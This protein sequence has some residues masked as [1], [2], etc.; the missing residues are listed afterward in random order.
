M[1]ILTIENMIEH[2]LIL[3]YMN[4]N[5]LSIQSDDQFFLFI[6]LMIS[7]FEKSFMNHLTWNY[8]IILCA[9]SFYQFVIHIQIQ[10]LLLSWIMLE[11][12]ILRYDILISIILIIQKL[13]EMCDEIEIHLKYLSSYSSDFNPIE[14]TFTELKIWIKKNYI[15]MKVYD[16]FNQFLEC[17]L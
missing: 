15:L 3:F 11:F 16:T 6:L 1:N 10:D 12:I 13:Q 5:Q 9:W 7:L 2:L 8:S 14:E 4:I 17:A